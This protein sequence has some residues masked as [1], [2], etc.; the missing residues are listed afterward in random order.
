MTKYR[1]EQMTWPDVAEAVRQRRVVL[2]PL[3]A[4]EQHGPHLPVDT[5]NLI[6]ASLC[7]AAGRAHPDEFVVAPTIP[8]GF[9]DHNMEFPGTVSIRPSVLLDYLFDVGH[10]FASAGFTR[11]V[12][13]NGHGSNDT[14]AELAVRRVTNET[15]A[16]ASLT[17]SFALAKAVVDAEPDLRTSPMGGVAHACEFETSMYLHLAPDLVREDLIADELPSGFPDCVEHDWLGGGPLKLMTWYSQRTASGTEG[18]P[19]HANREKGERLFTRST[20]LLVRIARE[21]R[22]MKL[23]PRTDHRPQPAWDGGLRTPVPDGRVADDF[24]PRQG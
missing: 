19:T 15:P 4:I 20:E 22:D 9:N 2:Q 18:T 11:M 21:F 3:A 6:V 10:S 13:V 17:S 1:L 8:Y 5:D 7:D 24:S 12:V 23:P 16:M 14:I